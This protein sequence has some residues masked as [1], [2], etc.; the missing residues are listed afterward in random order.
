FTSGAPGGDGGPDKA[1]FVGPNGEG[2][3]EAGWVMKLVEDDSDPA[4]LTFAWDMFAVGGEP[5]DGGMGF[6]NPDNLEFDPQG[7]LWIVTDMSTGT[8]NKAVPKRRVAADQSLEGK[9]VLGIYGNNSLWQIKREGDGAGEASMFA[10]GPMESELTGPFF[11]EDGS[12]L[13]IAAQHPGERNGVRKAMAS[14]TRKFEM[15]TTDG[16]TFLQ[17]RDVPVG[18]NWPAK[19][20]NA[21]PKPSVVAIRRTESSAS[22]A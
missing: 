12:T 1:V 18:S 6:A 2:D 17:K 9:D 22:I 4:A 15:K 3:Y 13:F 14:E 8:Q 21:P 10:Y 20:E 19:T 16:K 11:T 5:T 7:N